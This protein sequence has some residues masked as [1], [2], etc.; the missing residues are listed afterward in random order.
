MSSNFSKIPSFWVVLAI[1]P[2]LFLLGPGVGLYAAQTSE[3]LIHGPVLAGTW[4]PEKP[5]ELRA[6]VSDYLNRVPAHDSGGAI[7]AL[8]VPHAGYIY[9]GQVA[10]YSYKLLAGQKFDTVIVIGPSHYIPFS[11]VATYDCAGFRTPVGVVPLDTQ[12]IGSLIKSDSRIRDFPEVFKQEHSIE[13]QLPFL[14]ATLASFKLVPLVM[15][16]ADLS[17]C[18]RLADTLVESIKGKSVLIVASSDLSHYHSYETARD[19]DQRLLEKVRVMDVE[20]LCECLDLGKCEAC[21]RGPIITTMLAMKKLGINRCDVIHYANTG[22]A[23]GEKNSYR[24][25]VGYSAAAFYKPSPD[26]D[27]AAPNGTK[28]GIDLG[29][30][31]EE[32]AEL[33]SIAWKVIE[34][35]CSGKEKP[36]ITPSSSKLKEPSGAF[37]TIYKNGSLRGCIGQIVARKPLFEAVAEMAEAA[38]LQDPRFSPVRSDELKDLKVEI[39]V[40]TPFKKIDSPEEIEVGKHGIIMKRGGE[41][42]L[43]LP[44]VATEYGWDRKSFLENTCMKAGLPKDAWKDKETEIYI[45]SADVF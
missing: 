13:I 23:T 2:A 33:H 38:A 17:A 3:G 11:G 32:R 10:A 15:G 9:S 35:C 34:A 12:L 36:K 14:Q 39:S 41:M 18:R 6:Q 8:I 45:F 25:V 29:F 16:D 30:T 19:M 24:G 28:P 4:Y 37:V 31:P 7:M 22:D 27:G 5:D 20:G 1:L 43:L 21:G 44:Q 42:G 26:R 40:L